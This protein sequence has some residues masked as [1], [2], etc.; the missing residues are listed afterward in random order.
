MKRRIKGEA[1]NSWIFAACI[2]SSAIALVSPRAAAH[3]AYQPTDDDLH[4][5]YCL[6]VSDAMLSELQST[7]SST[8]DTELDSIRKAVSEL[9]ER[10]SRLRAYVLPK[11]LTGDDATVALAAA[12]QR[13][14]ADLA[15][16]NSNS[17]IVAC[18]QTCTALSMRN[19]PSDQAAMQCVQDCAPEISRRLRSCNDLS[20]LPF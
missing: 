14:K 20:W 12:A 2:C 9:S 8:T 7:A 19:A 15:T 10:V 17:K 13:G 6:S 11:M 1:M 4:A 16:L 18:A 5:A 3:Q